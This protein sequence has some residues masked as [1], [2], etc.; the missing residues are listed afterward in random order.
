MGIV[1]FL[2]LVSFATTGAMN[3]ARNAVLLH[4]I[5]ALEGQGNP[6]A[7]AQ[8]LHKFVSSA[9][10]AEQ[11]STQLCHFLRSSYLLN[12]DSAPAQLISGYVDGTAHSSDLYTQ[13]GDIFRSF[14]F[15]DAAHKF[16][17]DA[18]AL[19]DFSTTAL[20]NEME[21]LVKEID[22]GGRGNLLR[23]ADFAAGFSQWTHSGE[24]R[25]TLTDGGVQL[26]CPNCQIKQT[27]RSLPDN[28]FWVP[29]C[30]N[31]RLYIDKPYEGIGLVE[32]SLEARAVGSTGS[33]AV[34]VTA[35]DVDRGKDESDIILNEEWDRVTRYFRLPAYYSDR[36]KV[37]LT[38]VGAPLI[39]V[40]NIELR[41]ADSLQN[42]LKNASFEFTNDN[43]SPDYPSTDTYFPF[44]TVARLWNTNFAVGWRKQ[45]SGYGSV[46]ALEIGLTDAQ[47][48]PYRIGVQQACGLIM[49]GTELTL[50]ADI[51][52]PDDLVG[53]YA[54]VGAV[55]HNTDNTQ[56]HSLSL[57][58][59]EATQGWKH[60]STT[61]TLPDDAEPYECMAV[62][63]VVAE[64]PVQGGTN[65]ARFDNVVLQVR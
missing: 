29:G 10:T 41:R 40:R 18:L 47:D 59:K 37:R 20:Q 55:V 19:G 26:N 33:L 25:P 32:L 49:P 56:I 64:R 46:S 60:F 15:I 5:G 36:L 30:I 21:G 34:D 11:A 65:V 58:E 13:C 35:E 4:A 48:Y 31:C 62:V 42:R 57:S 1:T 14:G 51:E 45:V 3:V 24:V 39:E 50:E 8:A 43:H 61:L 23:N 52:L 2:L 53:A 12:L 63:Q 6:R 22:G 54:E 9:P 44:W 38:Q 28:H 7:A 17:K 16:Y 27:T